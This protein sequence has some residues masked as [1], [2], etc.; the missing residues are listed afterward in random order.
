MSRSSK[1]KTHTYTLEDEDFNDYPF[2][3]ILISS[4]DTIY[5]VIYYINQLVNLQLKLTDTLEFELNSS[6]CFLFPL[7]QDFKEKI[8]VSFSLIP[9]FTNTF[10]PSINQALIDDLFNNEA[11][12][13]V[14]FINEL[15]TTHYFLKIDSD[16]AKELQQNIIHVLNGSKKFQFITN[17]QF[18]NL[19]G[20]NEKAK[21]LF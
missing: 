21:F 17:F 1:L 19:K 11:Q 9:N 3:V 16:D 12:K 2:E 4:H 8:G 13:Q 5:K 18:D 14:L 6:D 20:K 15:N 10:V 7:F